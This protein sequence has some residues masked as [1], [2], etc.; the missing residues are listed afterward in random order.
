MI[1]E[2]ALFDFKNLSSCSGRFLALLFALSVVEVMH[3]MCSVLAGS[4]PCCCKQNDRNNAT[5]TPS[6]AKCQ[7]LFTPIFPSFL[8]VN[9]IRGLVLYTGPNGPKVK[10]AKRTVS[11]CEEVRAVNIHGH[12][13]QRSRR[14]CL[15]TLWFWHFSL[16]RV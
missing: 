8:A 11:F 13:Y 14:P 12:S 4:Y 10:E 15:S 7:W 3:V 5:F 16:C 2:M 1:D 6:G 9:F